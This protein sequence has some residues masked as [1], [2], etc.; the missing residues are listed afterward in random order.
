M[1]SWRPDPT[2]YPSA[3]L[4]MEAEPEGLAYVA[5]LNTADDPAPDAICVVDT[6]PNSSSYAQV[7]G[8]LDMPNVGDELHHFGWN[9]CSSALCPYAPH[10]H[11]ERRYLVVPGLRSSRIH[12]VD[13]KDDPRSPKIERVIEADELAQ[14]AGYSRPH[15]S[16]C[17]PEGIYMSALGAPDGGGPG[18]VFLLD[19][20]SFDV[21][22]Q[23]EVDRG[24]QN[25]A[26][27]I[28]WH[29]GYDT[30]LTSEW[31]TPDM[32]ESGL[33]PD[34]LG[35]YGHQLHIWDLKRRRHQQAID[36]G[37]EQQMVL[38]LRPAH[39][40]TK[41]H[42][43]VGVVVSTA[44]L[45]ASVWTWF[46]SGNGNGGW[47]V[48]KVIEIP[49]EPADPE[50]LPPALKPFAA[51]PP[52]ITDIDLS[53]D[54]KFLYVS[55]WGTGELRQYDVSDP[56]NPTQTGSVRL[57]GIVERAS[58]PANGAL[59]GGPQMVEISRDG[60]RVYLTNSLYAS[61]DKQFYP[62]GIDGWMVKLDANPD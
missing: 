12:I 59:N 11:V 50:V 51:V 41:A 1:P 27:D 53:L 14:R 48:R 15:T 46:R 57:G 24:P 16:H 29:L 3:R 23:W 38:E 20:E 42:G 13:V 58:H 35:Q 54:D 7:V 60:R 47:E 49:P 36:L 5:T 4:A 55:C 10:P 44:D 62:E 22:G 40:P 61:W 37:P 43:F 25:L 26:Y 18:G 31:G 21:L 45:T 17:G 30:M 39:D 32:V 6:D 8:R 34:L 28:W 33:N 52:L 19:H 56:F 9:A 2:F